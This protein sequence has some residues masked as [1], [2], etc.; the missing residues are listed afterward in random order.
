MGRMEPC[1]LHVH[2]EKPEFTLALKRV[3]QRQALHLRH[4]EYNNTVHSWTS[5][6]SPPFFF[7][8]NKNKQPGH[9]IDCQYIMKQ[10]LMLKVDSFINLE[11][12]LK[13]VST[14]SET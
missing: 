12:F 1:C 3:D 2:T 7:T 10:I 8:F 6:V 4:T 11:E 5:H 13:V 9:V 14:T